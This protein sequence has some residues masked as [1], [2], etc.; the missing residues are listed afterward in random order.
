M[1]TPDSVWVAEEDGRI[2]GILIA[3]YAHHCFLPLIVCMDKGTEEWRLIVFLKNVF[4]DVSKRGIQ[5]YILDRDVIPEFAKIAG[6]R[7][8][9]L[10]SPNG[11]WLGGK[12]ADLLR[13]KPRMSLRDAVRMGSGNASC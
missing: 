8:G 11:G 4:R 7:G 9:V 3:M 2:V 13:E 1:L 12:I 5:N 6:V 10:M